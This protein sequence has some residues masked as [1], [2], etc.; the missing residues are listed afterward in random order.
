MTDTSGFYK[1]D[2]IGG[3]LFGPNSVQGPN[4]SLFREE[5]ENHTYPVDGWYWAD[6]EAEAR[7]LLGLP[8][9]TSGFYKQNPEDMEALLFEPDHVDTDWGISLDRSNPYEYQSM[10]PIDGWCWFNSDAEA[11]AFFGLPPAPAPGG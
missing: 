1:L 3:F 7:V 2:G 10:F 11:R 4:V 8:P 9:N 6:S 5:H